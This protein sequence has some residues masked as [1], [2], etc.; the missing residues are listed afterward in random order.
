MDNDKLFLYG[1][2]LAYSMFVGSLVYIWPSY[3]E[4][5]VF[6]QI[7]GLPAIYYIGYEIL[8]DKQKKRMNENINDVHDKVLKLWKKASKLEQENKKLKAEQK[9]RNRKV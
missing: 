7:I 9:I 3:K 4:L 6:L 8:M 5:W 2:A 1:M